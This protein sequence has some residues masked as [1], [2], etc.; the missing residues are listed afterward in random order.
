V[1]GS[2]TEGDTPVTYIW[3]DIMGIKGAVC[4]VEIILEY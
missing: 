4:N 1:T 3:G 2:R